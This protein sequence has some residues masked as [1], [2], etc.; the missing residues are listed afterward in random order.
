LKA[1]A[2]YFNHYHFIPLER[3]CQVLADLYGQP[4]SEATLVEASADLAR[5]VAPLTARIK[6]Y[7]TQEADV[8]NFDETGVRVAGRLHWLH[9]ASTAT[10]THYAVHAKRGTPALKAIAILPGL[11]GRAIHDHWQSY[12]QFPG[13]T[14]GL[15]NAHHLRDLKF[16]AE[17]YRQRWATRLSTLLL[18]IKA[19]VDRARARQRDRLAPMQ[20]AQFERRYTQLLQHGFRANARPVEP[21][22]PVQR[23]RPK[24][25]P[26][27]NLLDRLRDHRAEVLAFMYDFR[28]PFD[29][30]QAER[31]LRM[32]K[33]K[34]KVSGCFRS[35]TGAQ[36]FCQIRTYLST[37]R[38]NGQRILEAVEAALLGRPFMPSI[39]GPQSARAG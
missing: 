20:L 6:A 3:T 36:V 32:M 9:S 8:V 14:H 31:D 29:N 38:K 37:V 7:L 4:F 12:F 16:V 5:R 33:V 23:G 26:P 28:V 10:V 24:Q 35:L 21:A 17:H 2:L 1:Q 19:A 39:L 30:N 18:D 11:Q 34:Q 15:C 25:S 27:K 13:V 22:R